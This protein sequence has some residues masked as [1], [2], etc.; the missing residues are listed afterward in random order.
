MATLC[1]FPGI[2][3]KLWTIVVLLLAALAFGGGY[4]ASA[5]SA[6]SNAWRRVPRLQLSSVEHQASNVKRQVSNI[7]R[8]VSNVKRQASTD[9]SLDDLIVTQAVYGE[10]LI[11]GKDTIVRAVVASSAAGAYD[12]KVTVD[13]DGSSFNRTTRVEGKR[14]VDIP[15]GRPT[16][17][18]TQVVTATVEPMGEITDDE[19]SNNSK[20]VRLVVVRPAENI[21]AFFLPVDWTPEQMER[22]NFREMFPQFVQDNAEFLRGTYPLGADQIEVDYTLTPH[23]LTANEKRLANSQGETDVLS[24][25]LLYA[26]IS[27]AARRVRPEVTLVIGVF[28]PGWFAK[29]GN[30]SALGLALSDVN[31][32]VTAQYVLSDASTSAHELAHLYWL[33][34]DY[35]YAVNPPRPFTWIDRSGYFVQ[36]GEARDISGGAQIPTFLSAYAPDRPFWVDTRIY[37]YLMAKFTVG[38]GGQVGEPMILAA[39][40][41]RQVEPDGKNYPSDYAAGYQRFESKQTVYVAVAAAD[42]RGG[43]TLQARWYQGNR[44]V[45][46]DELTVKAGSAWYAFSLRNRKGMPEGKYR[47]EIYLDGHLVK[48]SN[49]EVKRGK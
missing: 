20:T 31:G 4:G 40:L 5:Q 11:Y 12:V 34:E 37:E 27:L 15:V 49:F 36:R 6:Q 38:K 39:T 42:M 45:L 43:E 32:T 3:G 35:D 10:P 7:K 30:P 24:L 46:T 41:A 2:R 25:H 47:V 48:T 17:L 26:S 29:H 18:G 14:T 16:R 9:L 21:S 8:Q 22:Y 33:Y 19:L 28:P 1:V 23:M 13:F 44:N